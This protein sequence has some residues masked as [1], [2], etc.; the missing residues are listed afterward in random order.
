MLWEKETVLKDREVM[1]V[2]EYLC[3]NWSIWVVV[4]KK[5]YNKFKGI[6]FFYIIIFL[7][8]SVA[9]YIFTLDT[10]KTLRS[11]QTNNKKRE[12]MNNIKYIKQY[13]ALCCLNSKH[14]TSLQY[15]SILNNHRL[16]WNLTFYLQIKRNIE[17]KKQL[18]S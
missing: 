1:V 3:W 4:Q 5:G 7:S 8:F 13:P 16:I 14:P 17:G 2:G 18:K 12:E 10:Y 11:I 9:S 6:Q 15:F